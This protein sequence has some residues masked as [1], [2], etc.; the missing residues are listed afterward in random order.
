MS[1]FWPA[2][3]LCLRP[4]WKVL[5]RVSMLNLVPCRLVRD[6]RSVFTMH[7]PVCVGSVDYPFL[8]YFW[9]PFFDKT[10]LLWLFWFLW[11][12]RCFGF[13]AELQ[14]PWTVPSLAEVFHWWV[15]VTF[16][17]SVSVYTRSIKHT[18]SVYVRRPY[19]TLSLLVVCMPYSLWYTHNQFIY[20]NSL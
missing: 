10:V 16:G 14:S 2:Y 20:L 18:V 11:F 1:G 6:C 12:Y 3:V 15:A 9:N 8:V 7:G 19:D 5:R 17:W 4:L 13:F